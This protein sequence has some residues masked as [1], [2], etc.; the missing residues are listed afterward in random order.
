MVRQREAA[1]RVLLQQSAEYDDAH[2]QGLNAGQIFCELLRQ[3][4]V[5]H[6][7]GYPGGC[8][9]PVFDAIYQAQMFEMV[10]PRHEQGG[11]HMAE[12]YAQGVGS[13]GGAAGDVGPGRHQLHHAHAGRHVRRHPPHRV[14]GAG[15]HH[16]H[17]LGRLPGGG[18]PRHLSLLHQMVQTTLLT[19]TLT[20]TLTHT[21]PQP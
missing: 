3:H 7:F 5:K 2:L 10:L 20:F 18:R 12:G 17:R 1:R 8:I 19:L 11:G 14:H 13:A 21:A 15:A 9:L 4:D 16:R 6:I